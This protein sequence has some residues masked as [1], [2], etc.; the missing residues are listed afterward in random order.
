MFVPGVE[1]MNK[2]CLIILISLFIFNTQSSYA[3]N[4][5][6][7]HIKTQVNQG[8]DIRGDKYKFDYNYPQVE[9][10]N[11]YVQN[12]INNYFT[13]NL[14]KKSSIFS[15]DVQ[16][17]YQ[18]EKLISFYMKQ[19]YQEEVN[20]AAHGQI[21]NYGVTFDLETG[22]RLDLNDLYLKNRNY[23]SIINKKVKYIIDKE[24]YKFKAEFKG[25]DNDELYYITN[26]NLVIFFPPYLYS[27]FARSPLEVKIP[28]QYFNGMLKYKIATP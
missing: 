21:M 24:D 16:V 10:Q 20:G 27:S 4:K 15:Q 17:T 2:K 11:K 12:K 9:L 25:I 5:L 28:W 3:F 8:K 22:K 23:K 7:V 14:P 6:G 19:L 13:K 18:S 1:D 26:K